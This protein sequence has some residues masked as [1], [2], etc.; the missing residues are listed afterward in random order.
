[1]RIKGK[2]AI[3]TGGTSGIGLAI[4]R[5]FAKEGAQ[6]SIAARDESKGKETVEM[7][8]KDGGEAIFI[9]TDVSREE[10]VKNLV[11]TT[12]KTYKRLNVL[13]NAAGIYE[14]G[15]AIDTSEELWDRVININM[16][17]T[18]L[19]MKYAIPEMIRSGGGSIINISS[20]GG[21]CGAYN[22]L[23]YG[24]SKGGVVIM[25]KDTALD[26][27]TQN[28]RVNCICPGATDTPQ[29]Q[30]ALKASPDPE[31]EWKLWVESVP[32]KRLLKPE[33]VAY[34]ALFLASDESSGITGAILPV[35]GGYLAI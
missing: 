7:I 1:M 21:V 30:R 6:V 17:G 18:F 10:D 16:K 24:A 9:R 28:I 11:N 15:T 29:T 12:V 27:A 20:V 14:T 8:L 25:T 34:L 4:A 13:V 2:V 5:L 23:A 26:F 32:M 19:T 22:E 35:D 33:E 31:K 3:V